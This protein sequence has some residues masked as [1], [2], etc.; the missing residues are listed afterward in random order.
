MKST[1]FG[2]RQYCLYAIYV[3]GM[4]TLL[5][6]AATCNI[7]ASEL[8]RVQVLEKVQIA[9]DKI[10]LGDIATIT[11]SDSQLIQRLSTIMVGRAPL[12]GNSRRIDRLLN[13]HTV[14]NKIERDLQHRVND[15]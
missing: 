9:G 1:R 14:I 7:F 8:T 2:Y 5:L 6:P 10:L 3:I 15:G 11:G 4:L 13:R 12:P